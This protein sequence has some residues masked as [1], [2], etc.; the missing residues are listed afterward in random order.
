MTDPV[1]AC[2]IG[3]PQKLVRPDPCGSICYFSCPK[4]ESCDVVC[5]DITNGNTDKPEDCCFAVE[6]RSCSLCKHF[7][8]ETSTCPEGGF[9][10]IG[11][12]F[13]H[14]T[15]EDCNAWERK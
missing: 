6:K 14:R 12:P 13:K 7:D 1:Y 10:E 3:E 2:T 4:L 9:S 15:E 8:P 11:D 5:E